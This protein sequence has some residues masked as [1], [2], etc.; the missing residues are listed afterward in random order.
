MSIKHQHPHAAEQTE[1]LRNIG[2]KVAEHEN[3][4][5]M[6]AAQRNQILASQAIDAAYA[7]FTKTTERTPQHNRA[8]SGFISLLFPEVGPRHA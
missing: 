1:L 7:E 5:G 2:R 8:L 6:E 3:R 4:I